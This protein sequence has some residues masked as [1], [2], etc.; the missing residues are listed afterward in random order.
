MGLG[1]YIFAP[2]DKRGYP[3]Y[4]KAPADC[5]KSIKK[6]NNAREK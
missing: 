6:I 1:K 3:K 5:L 2:Y 4:T